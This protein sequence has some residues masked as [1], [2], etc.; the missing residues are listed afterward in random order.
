MKETKTTASARSRKIMYAT[1][2]GFFYDGP[3]H[4]FPTRPQSHDGSPIVAPDAF[5]MHGQPVSVQGALRSS[6]SLTSGFCDS[7]RIILCNGRG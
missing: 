5:V 6:N 1:I 7:S 3:L 2:D 4:D